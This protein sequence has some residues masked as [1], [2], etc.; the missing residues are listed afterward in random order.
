MEQ[1]IIPSVG[2]TTLIDPSTY[3]II[4]EGQTNTDTEFDFSI[5]EEEIR[6]G[7]LAGLL[8]KIFH[9]PTLNVSITDALYSQEYIALS[10]GSGIEIGGDAIELVEATVGAN[11][12]IDVS[13]KVPRD[14]MN[15]GTIG[16]YTLAG[17]NDWNKVTFVGNVATVSGL[18]EGEKVCVK[19]NTAH[20]SMT[21][22]NIPSAFIPAETI[23]ILTLPLFRARQDKVYNKSQQAGE[24][25]VPIGR[26]QLNGAQ[27]L[28][29]N[30]TGASTMSLSGTA[31]VDFTGN[32]T[33]SGDSGIYAKWKQ[34]IYN[35]DEKDLYSNIVV[36]NSDI[37]LTGAETETLNVLGI[38][39]GLTAPKLIDN[40]K[41]TFTA[42]GTSATVDNNGVVKVKTGTGQTV[43]DVVY[44]GETR[45]SAK[46]VVTVS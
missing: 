32:T 11:G 7:F 9:S 34:I 4:V 22:V 5:T 1:F 42:D 43:I 6:G 17:K 12:T 8:G 40:S 33:C 21:T 14:F 46:A 25:Q 44:T 16:W 28:S 36:S 37:E 35:Q 2:K 30:M 39:K 27:T 18:E 20:D 10:V 41:L 45:L 29:L 3:D 23:L 26:F 19:I 13:P 15:Q 38:G 31:T 24:I